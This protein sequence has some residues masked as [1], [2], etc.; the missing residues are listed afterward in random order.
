MGTPEV[1]RNSTITYLL[2]A[3]GIWAS[4]G[5]R[6][7][8]K[9]RPEVRC[10][11]MP[12]P[13]SQLTRLHLY[14]GRHPIAG[15]IKADIVEFSGSQIYPSLVLAIGGIAVAYFAGQLTSVLSGLSVAFLSTLAGLL[16]Y[17]LIAIVRAP[18]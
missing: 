11:H 5:L 17:L 15:Q 12:E 3:K 7:D 4:S 2:T 18:F 6:L 13:D 10:A 8:A 16:L 9:E 14:S 1:T